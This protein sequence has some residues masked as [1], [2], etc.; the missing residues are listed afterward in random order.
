MQ[1]IAVSSM[2]LSEYEEAVLDELL[3]MREGMKIMRTLV[4]TNYPD[5]IERSL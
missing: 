2:P 4:G 1:P 5:F 3:P